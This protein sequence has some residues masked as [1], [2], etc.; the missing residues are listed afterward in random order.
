MECSYGCKSEGIFQFKN[1]KMCCSP[2]VNK[3]PGKRDR[4]RDK[5]IGKSSGRKGISGIAWNKGL[6]IE[7]DSV[8]KASITYKERISSGEIK[9]SFLNRSHTEETK[10]L[11]SKSLKGNQNGNH[12]GD[13]KLYYNGIRMDS[14]WEIKTA[15]YFDENGIKWIYNEKGFIL[16]DGRKYYPDFFIYDSDGNFIKLV[17]VKGYFREKN[18]I[19]FEQFKMEYPTVITE[20]WD[21]TVLKKLEII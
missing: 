19:K 18:R 15:K 3:C 14:S 10:L 1:G 8:R 4:D 5:K 12:R 2:N 20:L 6:D 13:R 17:E 16:S 11:I 21:K 9:P 7:N